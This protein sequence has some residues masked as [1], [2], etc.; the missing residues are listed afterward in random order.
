MKIILT[1][2]TGMIGT[3]VLTQSINNTSITEIVILSRRALPPT[4]PTSPK[5]KT[6][7]ISDFLSYPSQVLNEL[8][9]AEACIWALGG[10]PSRFPDLATARKV[11]IDYPLAAAKAFVETLAPG[12]G[13]GKKF[14]F[15]YVSGHAVDR[16]LSK[17]HRFFND[18]IHIKGEIE[19]KLVQL[20]ADNADKLTVYL[21]R[22]GSV[23]PPNNRLVTVL[24]K[25]TTSFYPAMKGEEFAAAMIDVAF[26]GAEEQ[27]LSHDVLQKRGRNALS[28]V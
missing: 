22:P 20:E 28:G 23:I 13:P 7:I 27:A 6:I 15:I 25:L 8:V 24:V 4:H 17:Q 2:S 10:I 1:G 18:A 19:N 5:I 9:G 11:N 16:D 26:R 12:L 21:P 14:R 3:E